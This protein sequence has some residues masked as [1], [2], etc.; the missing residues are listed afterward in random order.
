MN[1]RRSRSSLPI[2]AALLILLLAPA[3]AA[4]AAR[5]GDGI[6][7]VAMWKDPTFQK[8]FVG[9]YGINADIEPRVTPDEV[10]ILEKIRP[11]MAQELPKAES[12]LVKAMK[13]DCSAILDFTLG[14]IRF[15]Q[16][17]MAAALA[18]FRKAVEKFP[19][20]RRAWRNIGLIEARDGRYDEAIRAFTRMIELGGGDSY[21]YGLL[22]FAYAS[23]T[24]YQAAETAYRSAL[25]LQPDNTDWRLGLTRCVYKQGKFQDAA[26]LLD[27]LIERY[28]DKTEFW[29]LQAQAYLG[30]KRP[31]D[32][33]ANLEALALLGKASVDSL[34][35]LGDLYVGENLLDL[36]SRA[37]VRAIDA[38]AQQPLARPLRG[39][40]TMTARGALAETKQIT[41]RIREVWS[42]R[43]E[44]ADRRRLLKVEA[45]LGMAEGGG[46][47]ETARILEEIVAL[48]PLD[49]EALLLLG[50]YH[51]RQGEPDRAILDFERAESIEA[52]EVNA[53]IRH[54]QVLVGMGRY[55][56][57]VPL[58]RRAQEIKPRDDI[59][60]YLDQVDRIA[61]ARR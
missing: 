24:D 41:N 52:F 23:K 44:E 16:D 35:D 5:G 17:Q 33:A 6:D 61:K 36:A 9:A 56:D 37:Y 27:V 4:A 18:D 14:G 30:M 25:L 45:R 50:Q 20:F 47:A 51:A 13:P 59:A 31:L 11:L 29:L 3:R 54:A 8:Q 48:D 53:R 10:K 46:D 28:P 55:A 42:G 21:S 2:A 1:T 22:G 15:Q 12:T 19:S 49:G 38:D 43:M 57:A 26:S 58:L 60:R 39:A 34:H 7:L 40:E 32:A